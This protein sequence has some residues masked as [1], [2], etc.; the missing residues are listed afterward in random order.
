MA[1]VGLDGVQRVDVDAAGARK[2]GDR[3]FRR[4]GGWPAAFDIAVGL[5]VC[6]IANQHGQ[7]ARS[8]EDAGLAGIDAQL[9]QAV[10]QA[11]AELSGHGLQRGGRQLFAAEFK[12]EICVHGIGVNQAASAACCSMGKPRA[13]RA[14]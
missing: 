14:S 3:F 11:L 2:A 5:A 6:N 7:A 9:G 12:Q 1:F 4:L 8:G 13:S 10:G